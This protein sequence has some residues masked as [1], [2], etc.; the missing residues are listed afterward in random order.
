ME[1][2]NAVKLID[3]THTMYDDTFSFMGSQ[4]Q[5]TD[6]ISGQ[7][8][9]L[10]SY[11]DYGT[12]GGFKKSTFALGCDV[13]THID[14]GSH[15]FPESNMAAEYSMQQLTAPGAVI[16]VTEKVKAT[17]DGNYGMTVQDIQDW[18]AIYGEIRNG[19]III[20]KTGWGSKIRDGYATYTGQDA[21]GKMHFPGFSVESSEW[22][23]ANRNFVGL[24]IDSPSLDV[25]TS[26]D[27]MVHQNLLNP[28]VNKYFLE[29]LNLE[30]VE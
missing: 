7:P 18:E 24:G 16:D 17:A 4:L 20:M 9:G 15:F 11:P 6:F 5:V 26:S 27:F 21:A 12:A 2:L 25:G 23:L 3:C 30:G 8:G 13:G 1:Y 10:E 19:S 22:L 28:N 14:S 29:N